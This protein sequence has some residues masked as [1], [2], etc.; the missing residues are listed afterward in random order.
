MGMAGV[1]GSS[2]GEME[3]TILEQQKK[4]NKNLKPR[5]F[6]NLVYRRIH[7]IFALKMKVPKQMKQILN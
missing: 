5:V 2:G 7:N 3:T 1:G 4:E 6:R